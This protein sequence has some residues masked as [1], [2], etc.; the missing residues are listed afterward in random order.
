MALLTGLAPSCLA[1]DGIGGLGAA[2]K[3]QGAADAPAAAAAAR[4]AGPSAGVRVVVTSATRS[5][6]V[7]SLASPDLS[8]Q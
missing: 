1:A 6:A 2:F 8:L 7:W 3:P 5:V 4:P